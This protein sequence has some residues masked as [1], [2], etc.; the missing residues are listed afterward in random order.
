[1]VFVWT[2][3][4]FLQKIIHPAHSGQLTQQQMAEGKKQN[5]LNFIFPYW[6]LNGVCV[7]YLKRIGAKV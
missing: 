4:V 3:R 2:W 7:L 6:S 5:K 1:M